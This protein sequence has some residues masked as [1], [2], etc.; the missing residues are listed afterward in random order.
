MVRV[1]LQP[2]GRRAEVSPGATLLDAAQAAGVE[3]AAVC[4]GEGICGKCRVRLVHGLLSPPSDVEREWL[5]GAE[6]AAG[7]RLAC[8]ARAQSD[9]RLDIPPESLTTAQRLQLEGDEALPDLDPPVIGV[10]VALPPATLGDLRADATRLAA[11]LRAAGTGSV[12]FDL[13][14]LAGLPDRLRM[15]GWQARIALRDAHVVAVLPAG[16]RLAGLA[17]DIGTTKLAAYLVDLESGATLARAGAPNPQVAYGE[18]VVS[19]IAY[20]VQHLDG[21][22]VLQ[23]RLVER[24]NDLAAEVCTAAGVT[25]DQIVAAAF[26]GNTA[27][28][29]L[30]LGLPVRQLG[31]AP[32]VA[33]MSDA[34]EVRAHE[35]GLCMAPG[36]T[37]YFPPNIAGFVGG[38]HVAMLLATG[39]H[40]AQRPVIALDIGTNTEISLVAGGR[41]LSCSCAS[42]PTFEGAHIRDGMRAAPGA[43]ERVQ[44][45]DGAV[46]VQTVGG[47]APVGICGSGIL[48]AVAELRRA[49][50]AEAS[51]RLQR[52]A[53]RVRAAPGGG[54]FELV[55]AEESG[56]RRAIEVTR[57]DIHEVQLAKGAIRAGVEALL[58][59]AGLPADAIAEFIIAG[60]FGTYLD[61]GSALAVGMFPSLPCERFR[62]VGNA[63]GAGARRLLLARAARREAESIAARAEYV[64]LTTYAGFVDLFTEALALA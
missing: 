12:A 7:M 11:S 41:L 56:H 40:R 38:D 64:E 37:V 25:R 1:D 19:R 36:A 55:P 18:D 4:G 61:L 30:V 53:M 51:G 42:G 2:V 48:D 52:G 54:A 44:I 3:L 22:R 21:R 59:V 9:L 14:V 49:G 39:A 35:I 32:Y 8:V 63:A 10:D 17:A 46:R 47:A 6:L 31:Q 50:V 33:A 58:Q 29:H 5:T 28:H 27:M 62:Q 26:V 57:R 16:A 20:A 23:A 34:L 45:V 43:I 60:A 24:L 15:Q 13:P